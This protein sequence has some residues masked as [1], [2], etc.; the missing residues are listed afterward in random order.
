MTNLT[1]KLISNTYKQ[2]MLVSGAVSNTGVETSLKPVQTGDGAKSALEIAV[3][4]L[5][6][7]V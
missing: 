7:L 5:I 3:M 4:V 6:L 1:G 2:V